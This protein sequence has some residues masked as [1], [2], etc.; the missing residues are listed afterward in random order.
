MCHLVVTL[1]ASV[2]SS[3]ADG[4]ASPTSCFSVTPPPRGPA[5]QGGRGGSCTSCRVPCAVCHF[6]SQGLLLAGRGVEER[7]WFLAPEV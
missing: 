3:K 2:Y 1:L 7:L 6:F 5:K 4:W